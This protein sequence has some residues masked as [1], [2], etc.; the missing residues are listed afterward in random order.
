MSVADELNK[1][2]QFVQ[3]AYDKV[4]EKGGT[5]PANK[6]LE[7]LSASIESIEGGG[8]PT[9]S[10][11]VP[12]F[13]GGEYGAIAYIAPG[14]SEVRYYEA[15][16]ATD[17][18][19]G[20]TI[21]Y[22]GEVAC[23]DNDGTPIPVA[24]V[25]AYSIG[26]NGPNPCKNT[27]FL[28]F[29]RSLRYLYGMEKCT[30]T[31]LKAAFLYTCSRFNQP[32]TL[33]EGITTIEARFLYSCGDF[34]QPITLPD[35]VTTIGTDFLYACSSFNQQVTLPRAL[36]AVPGSFLRSCNTFNSPI[37]FHDGITS[38]GDYFLYDNYTFNQPLALPNGLASIGS[39]F[40]NRNRAFSQPLTIPDT[41]TQI[42]ASFIN[43][44]YTF[45]GPLNVGKASG[46]TSDNA[47]LS[48]DSG[49][50]RFPYITG[51]ALTGEN[52]EVWAAG[53]PNRTT[54][55]YRKLIVQN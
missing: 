29:F 27:N 4:E 43:N 6:N 44:S 24:S 48:A 36:N 31:T 3:A 1:T 41:V 23:T 51:V 37:V 19:I 42:G 46:F 18:F 11:D 9:P 22:V 38:I 12:Y 53:L 45:I 28:A 7:N 55:P 5:L 14:T 8:I 40:L 32:I 20:S 13:D 21:E 35:T 16:S 2:K 52:A 17:I 49:T 15:K 54:S 33:P 50:S 39:Y 25:V 47:T 26:T 34:N 30:G 10:P